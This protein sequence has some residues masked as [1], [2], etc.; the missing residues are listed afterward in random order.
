MP[1]NLDL[2]L[3]LT[4]YVDS[5]IETAFSDDDKH[6]NRANEL[7]LVSAKFHR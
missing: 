4:G 6:P 1:P 5:V 7:A 2:H 3:Y